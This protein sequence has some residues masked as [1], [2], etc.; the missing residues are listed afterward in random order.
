MKKYFTALTLLALP[1][2]SSALNKLCEGKT[3]PNSCHVEFFCTET[4]PF[5]VPIQVEVW[6]EGGRASLH[7]FAVRQDD[8]RA[9]L[10]SAAARENHVGHEV[11]YSSSGFPT[12]SLNVDLYNGESTFSE[13]ILGRTLITPMICLEPT[14]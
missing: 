5:L 10:G 8:T 11:F 2:T 13:Q 12:F 9:E 7:K 4:E 6:R 3:D 1:L 14:Q